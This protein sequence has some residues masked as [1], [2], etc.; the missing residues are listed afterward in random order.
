MPDGLIEPKASEE[1]VLETDAVNLK[2]VMTIDGIDFR[3][4]PSN[5]CVEI[6]DV[7]G[8]EAAPNSTLKE[9]RPVIELDGSYVNYRHLKLL[10]DLMTHC[11]SLMAITRHGFHRADTGALVS[12]GD[13]RDLDGGFRCWRVR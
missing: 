4:A 2:Q 13:R 3:W 9:L 1:W 12:R 5:P 7:L 6:F 10:C 8:I 11:G